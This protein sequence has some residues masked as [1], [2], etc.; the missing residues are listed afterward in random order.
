MAIKSTGEGLK[1]ITIQ[2]V[3]LNVVDSEISAEWNSVKNT[4]NQERCL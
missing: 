4:V 3:S 2:T 1:P